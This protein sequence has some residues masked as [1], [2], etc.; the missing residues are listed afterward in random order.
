MSYGDLAEAREKRTA[1]E[2]SAS[3]RKGG[4]KRKCSLTQGTGA[5]TT[6]K[7]RR[8]EIEVAEEEIVAAGMENHCSVLRL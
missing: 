5:R 4:R 1:K 6:K 8:S 7:A 2:A 3:K